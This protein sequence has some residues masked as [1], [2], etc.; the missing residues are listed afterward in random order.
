MESRAGA[1]E[2]LPRACSS[3][4]IPDNLPQLTQPHPC[5][6]KPPNHHGQRDFREH[7]AQA[8]RA[9]GK[10]FSLWERSRIKSFSCVQ[11]AGVHQA[12]GLGALPWLPCRAAGSDSSCWHQWPAGNRCHP[13]SPRCQTPSSAAPAACPAEP[14]DGPGFS[15]KKPEIRG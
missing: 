10:P 3:L 1:M 2:Q 7:P 5:S 11:R 4:L 6:S 14:R 13:V 8:A 9:E 12:A 15:P